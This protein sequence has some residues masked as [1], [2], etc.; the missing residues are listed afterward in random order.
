MVRHT[1]FTEITVSP[2]TKSSIPCTGCLTGNTE[3]DPYPS[4]YSSRS[5]HRVE[6]VQSDVTGSFSVASLSGVRYFLSFIADA[7]R[8]VRRWPKVRI[9]GLHD[10][11]K[12]EV[13]A[14]FCIFRNHVERH[15]CQKLRTLRSDDGGVYL[16]SAFCAFL[17]ESS[18]HHE[19]S[20]PYSSQ[21][22]GVTERFNRTILDLIHPMLNHSA[23]PK[24]F[25]S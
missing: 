19:L 11:Q 22:K 18:I 4:A 15:T 16:V 12:S 21:H 24:F 9:T 1:F 23:T 10:G 17:A 5:E 6:L 14:K 25:R 13:F 8:W 20:V 7:S 2:S 3:H